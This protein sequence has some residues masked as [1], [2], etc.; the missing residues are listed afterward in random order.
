M[1]ALDLPQPVVV[2]PNSGFWVQGGL[3]R[4]GLKVQE[5]VHF[6]FCIVEIV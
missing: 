2:N 6:M 5:L 3:G 1:V 4:E